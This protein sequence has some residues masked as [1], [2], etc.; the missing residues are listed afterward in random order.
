MNTQ[1]KSLQDF[2]LHMITSKEGS[3]RLETLPVGVL[4]LQPSAL[5]RAWKVIMLE[6]LTGFS[7][8]P[9]PYSQQPLPRCQYRTVQR[10][11]SIDV[12]MLGHGKSVENG[13]MDGFALWKM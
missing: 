8:L 2:F 13:W 11:H 12:G 3:T 10:G 9:L 1:S 6:A 4:L 7:Q 5:K